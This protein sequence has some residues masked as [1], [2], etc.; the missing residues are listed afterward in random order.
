MHARRVQLAKVLEG[1]HQCLDP[2]GRVAVALFQSGDEAVF[3]LT[4]Q[5]VEN[6]R[7]HLM[8]VA[9]VGARQVVHELDAQC[10]LDLV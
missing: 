8:A 9:A 1:E 5:I 2:F 7:H 10:F 4:V 3:G 6:F